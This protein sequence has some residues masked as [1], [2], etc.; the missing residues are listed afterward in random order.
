MECGILNFVLQLL[1]ITVDL[2]FQTSICGSTSEMGIR[3]ALH[4]T[5]SPISGKS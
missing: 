1:L 4:E 2:N 5:L 3:K